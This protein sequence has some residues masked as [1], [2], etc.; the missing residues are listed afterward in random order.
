[1]YVHL[2]VFVFARAFM[3]VRERARVSTSAF[4]LFACIL[5]RIIIYVIEA[6]FYRCVHAWV[7]ASSVNVNLYVCTSVYVSV[8]LCMYV[9]VYWGWGGGRSRM[10]SSRQVLLLKNF[11]YYAVQFEFTGFVWCLW[12][13]ELLQID[14]DWTNN[15]IRCPLYRGGKSI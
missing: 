5:A 9:Y 11:F 13:S 10:S 15:G 6:I 14:L 4:L 12:T 8:G 3:Y 1:M 7:G 2:C